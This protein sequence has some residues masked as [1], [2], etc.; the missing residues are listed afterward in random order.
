MINP[1]SEPS[2][3]GHCW[4]KHMKVYSPDQQILEEG[5][6]K[7]IDTSPCQVEYQCYICNSGG[8][9]YSFCFPEDNEMKFVHPFCVYSNNLAGNRIDDPRDIPQSI[10]EQYR[11]L[12]DSN[13]ADQDSTWSN[14]RRSLIVD[15]I[16]K[17][18]PD[19]DAH[20]KAPIQPFLDSDKNVQPSIK[21]EQLQKAM[22]QIGIIDQ[23]IEIVKIQFPKKFSREQAD[24]YNEKM[25]RRMQSRRINYAFE[26]VNATSERVA[27]VE[28][29]IRRA[30][31]LLA[32]AASGCSVIQDR[33]YDDIDFF[34]SKALEPV[35]ND[36]ALCIMNMIQG[37]LDNATA[38]STDLLVSM[39]KVAQDGQ[40]PDDILLLAPFMA[41]GD[42]NISVNQREILELCIPAEYAIRDDCMFILD[43]DFPTESTDKSSFEKWKN[44]ITSLHVSAEKSNF[45]ENPWDIQEHNWRHLLRVSS[46]IGNVLYFYIGNFV[47]HLRNLWSSS[48]RIRVQI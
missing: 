48:W 7:S 8:C 43:S 45:G 38:V 13:K 9:G 35:A 15:E 37:N 34:F 20:T 17:A 40:N 3:H 19:F 36:S 47:L 23:L 27:V 10:E 30:F 26:K 28:C 29:L 41:Q 12:Y 11:S 16:K 42:K 31:F 2:E 33:L 24:D 6:S 14:E 4:Q 44:K 46:D 5:E 18:L 39:V 25:Q 32:Q 21:K 22:L 1:Q